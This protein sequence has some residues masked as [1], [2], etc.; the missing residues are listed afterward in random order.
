[1]KKATVALKGKSHSERPHRPGSRPT[2]QSA[3]IAPDLQSGFFG[4][5]FAEPAQLESRKR[6][7]NRQLPLGV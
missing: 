5:G 1:M 2:L 7:G 3:P 6:K 4:I